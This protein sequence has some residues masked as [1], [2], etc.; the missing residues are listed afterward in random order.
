MTPVMPPVHKIM[1]LTEK[2][3]TVPCLL[4]SFVILTLLIVV[5]ALVNRYLEKDES[6]N[7]DREELADY[8]RLCE[9][10][11]RKGS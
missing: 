11:D 9:R 10:K 8:E 3:G 6:E 5:T 2:Y 1:E 7:N 4:G